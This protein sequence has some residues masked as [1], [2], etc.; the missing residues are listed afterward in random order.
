MKIAKITPQQDGSLLIVTEDGRCGTFDVQPYLK[1]PAFLPIEDWAEFSR[2]H[3]GGYF[4]EWRC[5]ADLSA[6][7]IEA[8]WEGDATRNT[9]GTV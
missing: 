9:V 7:T 2:I 8:R 6:D 1:S 3:N 4:V 5:G